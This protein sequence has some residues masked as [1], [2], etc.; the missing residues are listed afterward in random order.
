[1]KLINSN[2]IKKY[3]K[4]LLIIFF[5]CD[6]SELT[7]KEKIDGKINREENKRGS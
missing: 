1:M 6:I 3:S 5:A 2:K 7:T 4:Q